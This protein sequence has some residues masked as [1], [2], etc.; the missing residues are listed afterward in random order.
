MPEQFLNQQIGYPGEV[1]TVVE[2]HHSSAAAD[3]RGDVG[4]PVLEAVVVGASNWSARRT[5]AAASPRREPERGL[6]TRRR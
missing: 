3:D 1:L 4:E 2:D 6:P 5:A